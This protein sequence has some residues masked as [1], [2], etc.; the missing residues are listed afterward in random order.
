M[1]TVEKLVEMNHWWKLGKVRR[2]F[3][4]PYRR[5]LFKEILKYM[6]L[7]QIIGIVGLRRV[8]KTTL[9]YQLIHYLISKK[10]TPKNIIYFSFDETR[11]ELRELFKVYEENVIKK[12]MGDEKIFVFLDEIQKLED[13]QNK[14]KIFYDLYPNLKFFISGSA[15]LNILLK[16]KES[17]AGRIFY[18]YLD[19][20]SFEEFLELR[21]KNL[22]EMRERPELWKK[23][24]RIELN[25]YLLKPFPEIINAPDEIAK[26]Y[27]RE[28]VIEKAVLRDLTELF[29][30]RE[31]EVMEKIIGTI[32]ANPG[33]MV[34]LDDLAKD[35]GV[36]RPVLSNYFYYLQC[37]FLIKQLKNF[38]G[39]F[40]VSSRKLKKYYPLHPCFA[41]TLATP[42][43][44]KIA[45]NLVAFKT[46]A[47]HYWR[48]RNNEVDFILE[49]K[50]LLPIEVKYKDKIRLKELKGLLKFMAKFKIKEA[51][52]I[53]ED[54]AAKEQVNG[55]KIVFT[56][57]WRWLLET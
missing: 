37:C 16:A 32:A 3:V 52:V 53:T 30:I 7:R 1:L 39:S 17:L 35:F 6:R 54:Y 43:V 10:I 27:I 55:G 22:K 29:E 2:E 15:S 49:D 11:A 28:A 4:P 12:K 5:K 51:L 18:F 40:K 21:G 31:I 23:E 38:R 50:K 36:S 14:L 34:N 26:R 24:L 45:E 46:K 25:N 19:L 20:L 47:G 44:G 48:E 57:L 33:L 42:E 13:W 41:L 8:G 56:P 9:L